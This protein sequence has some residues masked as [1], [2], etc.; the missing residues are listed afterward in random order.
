MVNVFAFLMHSVILKRI[1]EDL[2][3]IEL[4]MI[5]FLKIAF[6]LLKSFQGMVI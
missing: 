6:I 1:I 4:F 5:N 2:Y 3:I